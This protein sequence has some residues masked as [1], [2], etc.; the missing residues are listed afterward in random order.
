M[1][2]VKMIVNKNDTNWGLQYDC[3]LQIML[4]QTMISKNKE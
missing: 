4:K 3:E 1:S 2:S